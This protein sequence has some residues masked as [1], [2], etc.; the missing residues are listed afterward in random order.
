MKGAVEF[1]M[2]MIFVV[3]I[4]VLSTTFISANQ[5]ISIAR[6]FHSA[7]VN[8][9]ENSDFSNSVIDACKNEADKQG[10]QLDVAVITGARGVKTAEVILRYDYSVKLL[11]LT[12]NYHEIRG[13]AL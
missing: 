13:F 2:C 10:Y 3:L 1:Y 11:N 6:D 12:E 8:E 7:V 9:I 5:D 4:S